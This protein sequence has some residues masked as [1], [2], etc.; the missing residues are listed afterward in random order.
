MKRLSDY[1][2]EEAIELWAD[3]I[4]PLTGILGDKKI[5]EVVNSGQPK[6]MI[7]RE[8]LKNHA[9]EAEEIMLRIDPEPLDGL[10]I[11]LRLVNLLAELGE[12]DDIKSF[13]GYAGQAKTE[14]ES[15]GLHTVSTEGAG[16]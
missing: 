16:K 10:N 11:I 9:K 12:R 15:S 4:V 14:S 5:A 1:Q 7:A 3:L 13:F 8:I 2:G 6:L